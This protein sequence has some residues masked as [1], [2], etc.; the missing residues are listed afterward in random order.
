MKYPE[1]WLTLANALGS[2]PDTFLP[3]TGY[4]QD[5]SGVSSLL[6]FHIL[7]ISLLCMKLVNGFLRLTYLMP[8]VLLAVN[9]PVNKKKSTRMFSQETSFTK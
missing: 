7:W 8:T 1:V 2:L 4:L 5:S 6:F 9:F 3:P